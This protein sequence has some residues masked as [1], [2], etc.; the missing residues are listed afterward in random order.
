MPF[1]GRRRH[2]LGF[3]AGLFDRADHVE[4]LLG[5]IVAF[6]FEDLAE[7]FDRIFDLDVLALEAGKLLADEER[8]R[9]ETLDLTGTGNGFLILFAKLVEAENGDNVLQVLV[10]L[11]NLLDRLGR[12]VMLVADDRAGREYASSKRADRPPGKFRVP[13]SDATAP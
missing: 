9:E 7:S 2:L 11:Q 5:H 4:R 8:L 6:A 3:F 10:T 1:L 12:V 13:R